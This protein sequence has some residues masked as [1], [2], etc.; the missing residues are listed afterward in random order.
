MTSYD[1]PAALRDA[2]DALRAEEPR[3]RIRTA[4]TRLG[5]S[6]AELLATGLGD[7]V[8]R[9]TADVATLL[10]RMEALGEVMA[11]TRNDVF[12][13]EKTG[14][15]ENVSLGRHACGVVGHDIDLR[16]F[17]AFWTHGFATRTAGRAG[18]L[19]CLQFFDAH[20]VAV[21]KIY[22]REGTDMAAWDALVS[23]LLLDEGADDPG[24]DLGI[25]PPGVL[26]VDRPDADIDRSALEAG[27]RGM[28]DTHDFFHL[29]RKLEVGRLQALR[30]VDDEL[31]RPAVRS[32]AL[33]RVLRGAS[34]GGVPL[35]VFV[36][37]PGTF[38]IHH[39]PV[40][41]IVATDGGWLNVLDPGFNLHVREGE[42]A[43]SWIVR[44]PT[45]TGWV[46]SL[47]LYDADGDLLALLFGERAEGAPENPAWQE[48]IGAV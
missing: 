10:P 47:E 8:R 46:T 22:A 19:H 30:V 31:A 20:G 5:V 13:H 42:I 41:R 34:E 12:V 18:E 23:D 38:Q 37:S 27:W 33:G 1:S 11:L 6:E 35:M 4:A 39:G 16:I 7:G 44:K 32:D 2:W 14:V 45:E 3:L 24:V 17:P 29:L 28:A 40:D 15:Y 9:I 43:A 21:H 48:L 36:R 26:P 25:Q